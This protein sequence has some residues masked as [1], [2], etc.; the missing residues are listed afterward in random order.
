MGSPGPGPSQAR[1]AY[2]QGLAHFLNLSIFLTLAAKLKK[3]KKH[4]QSFLTT[5]EALRDA[6]YT[7]HIVAKKPLA[8][9]T[10]AK[11]PAGAERR[12]A[13]DDFTV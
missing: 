8:K 2:G 10:L 7:L 4:Q 5:L 13:A 3:I 6:L 12:S 9:K 11:R 1:A